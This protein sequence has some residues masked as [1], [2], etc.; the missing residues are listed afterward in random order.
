MLPGQRMREKNKRQDKMRQK[1]KTDYKGV[2]LKEK[3]IK[4]K[5]RRRAV[6]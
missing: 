1:N 6:G 5:K 4:E 3:I 2:S